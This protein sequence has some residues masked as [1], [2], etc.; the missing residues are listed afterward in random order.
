MKKI[1]HQLNKQ[2]DKGPFHELYYFLKYYVLNR[3][4][5]D[6]VTSSFPL[7]GKNWLWLS[8]H[9]EQKDYVVFLDGAFFFNHVIIVYTLIMRRVNR[10][11]TS[12]FIDKKDKTCQLNMCYIKTSV[13]KKK[14]MVETYGTT[15]NLGACKQRR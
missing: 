5:Q 15:Q 11:I 12:L 8:N 13:L 9:S 7:K 2:R 1:T 6:N 14:N 4:M 10:Q 3:Y